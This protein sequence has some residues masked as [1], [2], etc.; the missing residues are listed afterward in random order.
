MSTSLQSRG[1]LQ[2]L[3]PHAWS[4]RRIRANHSIALTGLVQRLSNGLAMV[5]RLAPW[6]KDIPDESDHRHVYPQQRGLLLRF[7][8]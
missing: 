2:A 5:L 3:E 8:P 1:D 7:V 6:I 4:W